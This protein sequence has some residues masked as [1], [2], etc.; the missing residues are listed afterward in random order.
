MG[1]TLDTGAFIA[2]ERRKTR[3]WR[4]I[5]PHLERIFGRAPVY[6]GRPAAASTATGSASTH[7]KEQKR[8]LSEAIR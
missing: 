4:F 8:V 7:Q 5:E 2:P 1:F 6:V 3:A